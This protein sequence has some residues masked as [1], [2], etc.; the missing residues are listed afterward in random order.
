MSKVFPPLSLPADLCGIIAYWDELIKKEIT[1]S[2]DPVLRVD[3]CRNSPLLII[4]HQTSWYVNELKDL[5][6]SSDGKRRR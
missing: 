2:A 4:L 6:M 1:I 3:V 5:R